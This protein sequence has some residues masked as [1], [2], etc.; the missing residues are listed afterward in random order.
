MNNSEK[1]PSLPLPTVLLSSLHV[2]DED[3]LAPL[4]HLALS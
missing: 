3:E 4:G 1:L 2:A